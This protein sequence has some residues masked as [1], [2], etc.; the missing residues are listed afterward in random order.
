LFMASIATVQSINAAVPDGAYTNTWCT[1]VLQEAGLLALLPWQK[2]I[3][4]SYESPPPYPCYLMN[5]WFLCCSQSLLSM[6]R[7][8]LSNW[9]TYIHSIVAVHYVIALVIFPIYPGLHDILHIL[10]IKHF[11]LLQEKKGTVL[12]MRC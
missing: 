12:T 7:N 5:P 11:P 4:D 9:V 1:T 8:V 3:Q 2:P 6:E 10:L